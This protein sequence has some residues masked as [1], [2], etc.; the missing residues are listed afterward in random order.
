MIGF[1]RTHANIPAGYYDELELDIKKPSNSVTINDPDFSD[2]SGRYSL[3]VNG[4]FNGVDFTFRSDE[5]FQIDVDFRPHL[6]ITSGQT[7]VIEISVDF[8]SWFMGGDGK[9]LDPNTSRNANRINKN[10]KDSFSDFEV[11]F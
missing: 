11:E 5:D 4:T 9:F 3:V 8:E 6:E 1:N 7:S 10:I 2:G